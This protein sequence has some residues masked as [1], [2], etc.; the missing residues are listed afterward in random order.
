MCLELFNL[1]RE[2]ASPGILN[3]IEA[4]FF[5]LPEESDEP[6]SDHEGTVKK[7]D[8]FLRVMEPLIEEYFASD[9][10]L[11]EIYNFHLSK[12]R[13]F[14]FRHSYSVE[15]GKANP[16]HKIWV[17]LVEIAENQIGQASDEDVLN[18]FD[19]FSEFEE[20]KERIRD[21]LRKLDLKAIGFHRIEFLL[22]AIYRDSDDF[23][24]FANELQFDL[25]LNEKQRDFVTKLSQNDPSAWD[26]WLAN[27]DVVR[28]L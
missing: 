12:Q 18:G 15:P 8:L 3:L 6:D 20:G 22:N 26:A 13:P 10:R 5:S 17:K 21:L 16:F 19:L 28:N 4:I 1:A 23:P 25:L 2:E 11:Q 27:V 14:L 7:K 24:L 9:D